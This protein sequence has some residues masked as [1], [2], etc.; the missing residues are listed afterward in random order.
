MT[1][2]LHIKIHFSRVNLILKLCA[3]SML[4]MQCI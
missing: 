2:L 1:L 4:L 3:H